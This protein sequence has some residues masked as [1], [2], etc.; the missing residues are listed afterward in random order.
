MG[1]RVA[2]KPIWCG[3][4]LDLQLLL[5]KDSRLCQFDIKLASIVGKTQLFSARMMARVLSP[6]SMQNVRVSGM[7]RYLLSKSRGQAGRTPGLGG[8]AD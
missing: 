1:H 2:H 5:R 3:R 6:S 4:F 7:C 8:Q